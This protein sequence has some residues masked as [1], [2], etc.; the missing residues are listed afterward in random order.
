MRVP[1]PIPRSLVRAVTRVAQ[2]S[3]VDLLWRLALLVGLVVVV[4]LGSVLSGSFVVA[5]LVGILLFAVLRDDLGQIVSDVWNRE[6]WVWK[7]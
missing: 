3:R 5:T 7:R 4:Y 1:T 6:F 2:G